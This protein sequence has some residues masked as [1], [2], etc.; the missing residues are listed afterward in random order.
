MSRIFTSSHPR[1]EKNGSARDRPFVCI[2][3]VSPADS[4]ASR[5]A[6]ERFQ[7]FVGALSTAG[8]AAQHCEV[9][10][11][12]G[13]EE[14]LLLLAPDLVFS[15]PD[16][17]PLS[18]AEAGSS[19]RGGTGGRTANV[20][21]VLESMEI[22]YIGS[23]PDT[24]DLVL[25]KADLK[26]RWLAFGVATPPFVR[27][28][29]GEGMKAL[30][31]RKLPAF[32]IIVKPAREGNSRGI[33]DDSVVFDIE[34]LA[35][36][37]ERIAGSHG[38]LIAEQYVGISSDFREFTVSMMGSGEAMVVMPAELVFAQPKRLRVITNEDKEESRTRAIPITDGFLHAAVVSFAKRAFRVAGVR[39]YARC[40][41]AL[42]CGNLTAI[43]VN[44]Q[45]MVPDSWFESCAKHRGLDENQYLA[46]I[47]FAAMERH[48]AE[49]ISRRPVPHEMERV[50]PSWLYAALR[51]QPAEK[52]GA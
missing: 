12:A 25:S 18:T 24:I 47:A 19:L 41:M 32:P 34:S 21:S 35:S 36:A 1:N 8:L 33:F 30:E 52:G 5:S 7:K 37:V 16:H 3:S 42:A 9:S 27:L 51:R 14:T 23:S 22:P 2:L 10:D 4:G 13:M 48:R 46:A 50:L 15:V 43:E 44:G 31:G 38:E 26:D 28:A 17:L 45:P 11:I 39:D 29:E 6:R 40:D 20:H 49:G